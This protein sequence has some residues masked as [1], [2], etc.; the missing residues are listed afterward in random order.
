[1]AEDPTVVSGDIETPSQ[2]EPSPTETETEGDEQQPESQTPQEKIDWRRKQRED[3]ELNAH[4]QSEIARARTRWQRQQLREHAKAATEANDPNYSRYVAQ[5]VAAEQ[6]ESDEG[7]G[8][9]PHD[10]D[11]AKTA[12]RVQPQ[13]ERMLQLDSDGRATNPYYVALHQRVG[14]AAMDKRYAEDPIGFVNWVD[15]QILEM[16]V[17]EKV[18]KVAPSL[19][20]AMAQDE[21][22]ARLRGQPVP[23]GGSAS[24]NGA[25][26]L[27]RYE[28]MTFEERQ[29]LRKENPRAIDDMIARAAR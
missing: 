16:R 24:A 5:Q 12:D 15:E 13:L 25:L 8:S 27:E 10:A 9:Q 19:A 26:T 18:K 20:G 2:T 3:V 21:A 11:W 28:G 4:V 22:H 6:D 17:D 23:I 1:M 29:K 14:R 7:D